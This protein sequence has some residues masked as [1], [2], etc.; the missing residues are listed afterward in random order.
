MKPLPD[1]VPDNLPRQ[2]R[3]RADNTKLKKQ[4]AIDLKRFHKFMEFAQR[5]VLPVTLEELK[6]PLKEAGVRRLNKI[7]DNELGPNQPARSTSAIYL[8]KNNEP[9][10]FY[11]GKRMYKEDQKPPVS[12]RI[13]F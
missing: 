12:I 4:E 10:L 6:K 5:I 8:D 9:V 13:C 2:K 1:S 3:R 11:F 7:C